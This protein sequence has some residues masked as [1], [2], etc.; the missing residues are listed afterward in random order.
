MM[1]YLFSY[2]FLNPTTSPTYNISVTQLTVEKNVTDLNF[3][4]IFDSGTSFT[5]LN[6]PVYTVISEKV[7]HP[8][9]KSWYFISSLTM[10][11]ILIRRMFLAIMQFNSAAKDKRHPPDSNFPFEYC[12]ERS[13]WY[14]KYFFCVWLFDWTLKDRLFLWMQ[15]KSN[16]FGSWCQSNY[17]RWNPILRYRSNKSN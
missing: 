13:I 1:C 7:S 15:C 16:Y 4:A 2:I 3:T 14:G 10:C 17:G 9:C 6:D 11:F 5:Y 12:Y 8:D